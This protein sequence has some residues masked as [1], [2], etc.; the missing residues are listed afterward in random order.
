MCHT[1][2][3]QRE[4]QPGQKTALK[5]WAGVYGGSAKGKETSVSDQSEKLGEW[6][7]GGAGRGISTQTEFQAI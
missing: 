3:D 2:S 4:E 7:W 6:D 5:P 1:D